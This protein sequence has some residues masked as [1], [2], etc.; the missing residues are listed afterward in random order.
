MRET[1]VPPPGDEQLTC[2]AILLAIVSTQPRVAWHASA[3]S[4]EKAMDMLDQAL[5]RLRL[6]G[7]A[8]EVTLEFGTREQS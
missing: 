3:L 1:Y 7:T 6:D 4:A 5:C 2:D 8:L